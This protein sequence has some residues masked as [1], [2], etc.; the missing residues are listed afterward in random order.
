MKTD[1]VTASRS[2]GGIEVSS[3]VESVTPSDTTQPRPVRHAAIRER[4][5]LKLSGLR[6]GV[7]LRACPANGGTARRAGVMG[8]HIRH[9]KSLR[10]HHL[11]LHQ[12]GGWTD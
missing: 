5:T 12:I 6:S 8:I 7:R 11:G 1:L 9:L 4:S 2:L 10:A 3:A